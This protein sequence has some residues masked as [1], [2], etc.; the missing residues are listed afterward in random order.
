MSGKEVPEGIFALTYTVT[1][2][3][4]DKQH[5]YVFSY[6][7]KLN[8]NTN[9]YDLSKGEQRKAHDY[10]EMLNQI[11]HITKFSNKKQL[12]AHIFISNN[13]DTNNYETMANHFYN[14]L[15]SGYDTRPIFLPIEVLTYLHSE[16]RKNHQKLYNARNIFMENLH[17][18]L[19]TDKLVIEKDDIEEIMEEA[20]DE[21]LADY[22]E[23]DTVKV[24]NNV[25]KKLKK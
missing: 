1:E 24:R 25:I 19:I 20:L 18:I 17:K 4:E 14:K 22:S 8:K 7:C 9:G 11:R 5:Q 13:F 15:P 16:Y 10:V 23:I 21:K 3:G 6:D 2:G 12:S